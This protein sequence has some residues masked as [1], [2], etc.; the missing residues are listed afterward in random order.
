MPGI[1]KHLSSMDSYASGGIGAT[2][3]IVMG[4]IYRIYLSINHHRIRS[5]CCGREVSASIDIEDTTPKKVSK[6]DGAADS[7]DSKRDEGEGPKI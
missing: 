6:V 5:T 7:S 2:A 1:F 4:I 3:V